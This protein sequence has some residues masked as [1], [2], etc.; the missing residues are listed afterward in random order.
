MSADGARTDGAAAKPAALLFALAALLAAS[1]LLAPLFALPAAAFAAWKASGIV[2]FGVYA[3][4]RGARL[5]A[6]GLFFSAVGDIALALDPPSWTGGM[7]AFGLAHLLYF[8][9]FAL[10]LRR[11]GPT[12]FAPAYAAALIAGSVGLG[13]WFAPGMGPL[14]A[15]GLAYH[16]VITLMAAAALASRAPLLARLGALVFMFSDGLIALD[17]Y[18]QTPPPPGAVW[19]FYAL[20]QAMLAKGFADAVRR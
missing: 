18:R 6:A 16:V 20:A 12:K 15:P 2:L 19:F 5:A 11:D 17:L 13:F 14:L 3:A 4:L 7:A 1:H 10:I 9:A 8:A